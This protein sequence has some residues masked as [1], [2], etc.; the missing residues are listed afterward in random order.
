MDVGLPASKITA[1]LAEDFVATV[2]SHRKWPDRVDEGGRFSVER[3]GGV[4]AAKNLQQD[5]EGREVVIVFSNHWAEPENTVARLRA[6]FCVAH[7][8]THP[9]IVR[10]RYAAG[11]MKDVPHPSFTGWE[12]A[13]SI[14]RIVSDEFR[15][16]ALAALYVGAIVTMDRDGGSPVPAK[17]WWAWGDDV[18]TAAREA[19]EA[20][21]P[22]WPDTVLR[23][24][25]G[26][27]QLAELWQRVA[28]FAS[29]SLTMLAHG[30]AEMQAA[31]AG[32]FAEADTIAALPAMRLYLAEPW[33]EFLTAIR[34]EAVL[35]P[36]SKM[37]AAEERL[38]EAGQKAVYEIWRRLGVTIEL[39]DNRQWGMN[40]DDP[41]WDSQDLSNGGG[42]RAIVKDPDI[43]GGTPMFA[44]THV[45]V[46]FLRDYLAA[47]QS[48]DD[49]LVQFPS[50]SQEVAVAALQ[51]L[52]STEDETGHPATPDR[53]QS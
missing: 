28:D 27:I 9:I 16:D 48:L 21:Y 40:V 49:F 37:P 20:A 38:C 8:L 2:D 25:I 4:V 26:Q 24:R 45:P 46:D 7:E 53:K 17:T 41:I 12:V 47:G 50:V 32:E 11:V 18:M 34:A 23:Y 42:C 3:L 19:L 30:Q 43:A 44:G 29:Q 36:L 1:I 14:A 39:H 51:E 10:A 52:R 13:R 6:L 15:A 5:D 35:E 31:D 22:L 33:R